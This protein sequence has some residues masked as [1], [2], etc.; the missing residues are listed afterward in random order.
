MPSNFRFHLLPLRKRS[1]RPPGLALSRDLFTFSIAQIS[2]RYREQSTLYFAFKLPCKHLKSIR[3][4][5]QFVFGA[6]GPAEVV[7]SLRTSFSY[8]FRAVAS[9]GAVVYPL[10]L[11]HPADVLLFLDRNTT[12]NTPKH[13]CDIAPKTWCGEH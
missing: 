1:M 11:L 8:S 9:Y 4:E 7:S 6:K 10:G 2:S 3:L 13:P 12:H 5:A